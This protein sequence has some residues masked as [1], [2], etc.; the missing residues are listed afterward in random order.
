M[1]NFS[2]PL[3]RAIA[4][5]LLCPSFFLYANASDETEPSARNRAKALDEIVVQA[6]PL[7][8]SAD[9]SLQP[10]AVLTGQELS[11]QNGAQIGQV[12]EQI[13]GVQA[14]FFGA[15][16]SRPIIRG[17]EGARVQVL[18]SGISSLDASTISPDH[19][20]SIEPF[21]ADQIEVLKGPATL[22]YGSGAIA[23][24][25]N[26]ADG[27]LPETALLGFSGR[28]ELSGDSVADQRLAAV[29][30]DYG[31]EVASGSW[32]L[33]VD[34]VD[35]DQDNYEIP[36]S[37]E[38]QAGTSLENQN[39]ALSLSYFNESLE[40]GLALSKY[41]SLYGIPEA[42]EEEA[43]L[44]QLAKAG[45]EEGVRIDLNQERIDTRIALLNPDGFFEK[46][47]LRAGD[48]DYQH[49][50]IEG[51]EF[52]TLF[53]VQSQEVRVEGLH[54]PLIAEG[55]G[56]IGLTYAK[57][58]FAA[59]GE[60][61]FVPF[62]KSDTTGLFSVQHIESGAWHSDVGVRFERVRLRPEA[63][64]SRTDNLS[65]LAFATAW[66]FSESMRVSLNLDRAQ[67]APVAEEL[68][69]EGAHIATQSY[70]RGDP[71]LR[72]ETAKNV[73]LG[74][75]YHSDSAHL[76]F[77]A[78]ENRFDDF[79]YQAD[80]DEQIEGLP[81][82]LWAQADARFRGLEAQAIWSIFNDERGHLR[83]G[84]QF[85]RVDARLDSGERLP[86][87]APERVGAHLQWQ[88]GNWHARLAALR[89]QRQDRVGPFETPTDGFTRVDFDLSRGFSLSQ[90]RVLSE[91]FLRL[92]NGT[93]QLARVH[94]SF[95]K[96]LAPLPGRNIA[97]GLRF[98][99]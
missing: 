42:E 10:V 98:Y 79:I 33:H 75:H 36:D 26:I 22:L 1:P 30:L 83:A 89:Y 17:L 86:R 29:R 97:V 77:S 48:N 90:D 14:S 74:L 62:S 39:G 84:L 49:V 64:G 91:V 15:G 70:E 2:R 68:F 60:E 93:D 18:S 95:L 40:F 8:E 20:V 27:R 24:V 11:D 88:S 71:S 23:G 47:E 41:N 5:A 94:T 38:P 56:A 16:V 67:R 6:S 21:L 37:S 53:D 3:S 76:S 58:D 12:I 57:R 85:D 78:F 34:G 80:T 61:A 43:E 51:G 7:G 35:R 9:Q 13:P 45:E 55:K 46:F 52:G 19:A 54:K 32:L 82:R 99:W 63:L 73:E 50:E 44:A 87:I 28:A 66:E 4:V 72:K 96:D 59:I 81:L 92:R 25:V 31:A 65:S 69:S